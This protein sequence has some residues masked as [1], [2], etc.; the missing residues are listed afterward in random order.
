MQ[1]LLLAYLKDATLV[2][3]LTLR[4]AHLAQEG[5]NPYAG[6]LN[7]V[8]TLL[9]AGEHVEAA[10]LISRHLI[11]NY[12]M[13]AGTHL[14]LALARAELAQR[15]KA[16]FERFLASQLVRGIEMT[17]EG[18]EFHPF[19]VTR[20]SDEYDL[21]IYRKHRPAVQDLV[22]RGA[23]RLDRIETQSGEV[24]WFDITEISCLMQ[25]PAKP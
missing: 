20:T 9:A 2:N 13:S 16:E 8:G 12:I 22:E 10:A 3:F 7:F 23:M 21:L 14:E 25:R 18:T 6:E 24:F 5:L 11:P 1:K 15:E 4:A 19:L 17:G